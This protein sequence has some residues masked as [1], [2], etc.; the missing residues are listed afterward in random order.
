MQ[1]RK[2]TPELNLNKSPANLRFRWVLDCNGPQK[3]RAHPFK[4]EASHLAQP[5]LSARHAAL[6]A[7]PVRGFSVRVIFNEES[8]LELKTGVGHY[9]SELLRC[10][11]DPAH[12][13][14]IDT[15]PHPSIRPAWKLW[16]RVRPYSYADAVAG[17]RFSRWR[18]AGLQH[19]RRLCRP[20][21][22]KLLQYTFFSRRYDIYHEPNYIPAPCDCPTVTTFHDLSVVLHPEWHPADRVAWL[23]KNLDRAVSQSS[24]FLVV[25]DHTRR[26]M[27]QHLGIAPDRVMRIYNGIRPGLCPLAPDVI[28]EARYRLDLPERYLLCVGTVEPRKNILRLMQA[29]CALPVALRA[30]WPLLLVGKWGWN[31]HEV[32]AYFDREARQCG[33][34]QLGYVRE[35]DLPALYNGARALVYPSLYEGFGLPPLEMMACGGAVIASTA[36]AIAEV[37]APQAHLIDPHDVDGWRDAM[38]RVV[39]DDEWW[40]SLRDGAVEHARPFTWERC[41]AE[42]LQVYRAVCAANVRE[43]APALAA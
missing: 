30:R 17:T 6:S 29:Y 28:A 2:Q 4:A 27:I 24:R 18:A 3:R 34:R 40:E 23:E 43:P 21:L 12:G 41:A 14:R 5:I 20:L 42:T 31:T 33:V 35:A 22:R 16:N 1:S 13:C 39:T 36:E 11:R 9:A 38:H 25:S 8:C 19:F 7:S 26:E 37:A 15:H 10:L 32:A